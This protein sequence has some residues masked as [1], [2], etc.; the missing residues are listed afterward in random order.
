MVHFKQGDNYVHSDPTQTMTFF[1]SI[2]VECSDNPKMNCFQ[3]K[4]TY[5]C[6]NSF[7]QQVCCQ[8]CS[9]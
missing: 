2:F 3:M 4:S 9:T 8:T 5:G 1:V 7:I 6:D